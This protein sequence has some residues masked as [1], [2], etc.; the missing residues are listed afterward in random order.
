MT[1]KERIPIYIDRLSERFGHEQLATLDYTNAWE[2]LVATIL[3]AQCTDARVNMVTPHLF[4]V[5]PT[6]E[7]MMHADVETLEEI[8]RSIGFFRAKAKNLIGCATKV[9]LDFGGE[10]PESIE[11]LTSLPGVGRKTANV[12][13]G[14]I[15]NE[16][17]IV[18]DTHVKRISKLMG[19]TK[20][21]DPYLVEKDLMKVLP[22]ENWI[23]WNV[24]LIKLGREICI[25]RR[26]KCSECPV[27]DTC[28]SAKMK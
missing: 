2:L 18:V 15:Y 20:N 12:V 22:K 8:I 17:S 5:Y 9:V 7:A 11:D 28:P 25:A 3:S 26:P 21:E 6:P 19:L 16:P 27:A 4:E 14:H 10:V 23:D 1:K 24:W 13:R